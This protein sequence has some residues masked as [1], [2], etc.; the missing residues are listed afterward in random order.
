VGE[1]SCVASNAF[2]EGNL[3]RGAERREEKGEIT[4]YCIDFHESGKSLMQVD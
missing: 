4:C 3:K 1:S 2:N